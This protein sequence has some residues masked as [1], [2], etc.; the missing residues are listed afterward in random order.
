MA[1]LMEQRYRIQKLSKIEIWICFVIG[2]VF[3]TNSTRQPLL[4]SPF[5]LNRLLCKGP[6]VTYPILPDPWSSI[7]TGLADSDYVVAS[8]LLVAMPFVPSSVLAPTS[9]ARSP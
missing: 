2:W 7:K 8:L 9:E 3:D 1:G 6:T 4:L 5:E